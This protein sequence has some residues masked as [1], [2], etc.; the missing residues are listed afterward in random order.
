MDNLT[1][2]L[3]GL[4]LGEAGLR[5]RTRFATATLAIGANLPDVDALIYLFGTGTDALAFRR[6]HTHGIL[7]LVLLPLLLTGAMLLLH[8]WRPPRRPGDAPMRPLALLAL[9]ALAVW[10]HPLLDWLNI[11][12]VRLLMPFS[13]RWFYGDA[14]FI[15]DPWVWLVL[16]FGVAWSRRRHRRGQPTAARPA[17]FA[18]AIA[19]AYLL[20]M[21]GSSRVGGALV[22]AQAPDTAT[23]TM[24][25]PLPVTPV[26]RDVVRRFADGY[27]VG[28]LTF[29]P[30]TTY[31]PAERIG[32][33]RH[34]PGVDAAM[35]TE[36]GREFLT[37]AR[38][39]RF[40]STPEGDSIRV[41]ISD[42]RYGTGREASF[43]MVEIA[44]PKN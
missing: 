18:L 26:T 36:P 31:R 4:A 39:P 37:W 38:F 12:G 6:G 40:Q 15:I 34:L 1:H 8:R 24:I 14:L 33:G 7:A 2:T 19:G 16:G 35:A 21:I 13:D 5:H 3:A 20:V 22:A 28:R 30:T 27:E 10:S 23:T 42:M 25:A 17:R 43:A 41:L 44:V 9:A 11:Y 32:D 29:R